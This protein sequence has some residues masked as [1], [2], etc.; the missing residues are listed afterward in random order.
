VAAAVLLLLAS[1]L[2]FHAVASLGMLRLPD[3]FTR[4]HAVSKAETVGTLLALAA[5]ALW[6]GAS[7]TSVKVGFIAVFFFLGTPAAAHAVARAAL[8]TGLEPWQRGRE[9]S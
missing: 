2:V 7:L 6:E 3:F 8:R 4:L 1:G 5:V 9:R